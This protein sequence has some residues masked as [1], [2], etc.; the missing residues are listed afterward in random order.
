MVFIL[1]TLGLWRLHCETLRTQCKVCLSLLGMWLYFNVHIYVTYTKPTDTDRRD[2]STRAFILQRLVMFLFT[3]T[4]ALH[5][6]LADIFWSANHKLFPPYF[7]A[8]YSPVLWR[9]LPHSKDIFRLSPPSSTQALWSASWIL[10]CE[11]WCWVVS[12]KIRAT[13]V[14]W[15]I[16]WIAF[17]LFIF[18]IHVWK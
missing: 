17:S 13:P 1:G 10:G 2:I 7:P 12:K 16:W 18:I 15:K 14:F 4:N 5:L 6:K 11:G 9:P 8:L 3:S